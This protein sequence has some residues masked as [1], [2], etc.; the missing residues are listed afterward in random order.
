MTRNLIITQIIKLSCVDSKN[1]KM[2]KTSEEEKRSP[3][4]AT[5]G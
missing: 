3:Y 2:S 1:R 5:Y 4:S